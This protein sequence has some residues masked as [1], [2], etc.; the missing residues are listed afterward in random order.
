MRAPRGLEIAVP[1][2]HEYH[3]EFRSRHAH[4]LRQF[5]DTPGRTRTTA[6][7]QD[8]GEL[9]SVADGSHD[10]RPLDL[11]QPKIKSVPAILASFRDRL[12]IVP[13]ALI[14]Q[15]FRKGGETP[16]LRS[17]MER[18]RRDALRFLMCL[19]PVTACVI[20]EGEANM[21][22]SLWA[23]T[24]FLTLGGGPYDCQTCNQGGFV[25]GA[26]MS[27]YGGMAG[28]GG[29]GGGLYST[30][31]GLNGYSGS[32]GDTLLPFDTQEAW[33]H[34]YFQ[35][36]GANPGY[37]HF[38]PY[39]YKHV[40]SQTDLSYRWGQPHGMPYSQQWW[41]RYQVRASLTPPIQT[42]MSQA[43]S[44]YEVEMARLRA[45]RDFQAEQ[46]RSA[47]PVNYNSSGA[48]NA[49]PQYTFDPATQV[50]LQQQSGARTY[51][52]PAAPIQSFP[53][54][55]EAPMIQEFNPQFAPTGP[56]LR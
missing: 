32:N 21:S 26:P 9:P 30:G 33:M 1:T 35:E 55:N 44:N 49:A 54:S 4:I 7:P 19:Q 14:A 47:P 8:R 16:I 48:I 37:T 5:T 52:L 20:G 34:G 22:S 29:T 13:I 3:E 11:R 41:H 24:V 42:Q 56:N 27:G 40:F 31:M 36:I 15:F 23:M 46:A 50:T 51:V 43:Q 39:N 28:Y 12:P 10:T 25:S 45:W 17:I 53:R 6:E 18:I 2:S 38:R